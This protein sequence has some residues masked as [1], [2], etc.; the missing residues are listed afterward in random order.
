MPLEARG[1]WIKTEAQAAGD[2]VAVGAHRNVLHRSMHIAYAAFQAVGLEDGD[3]S[4]FCS[5]RLHDARGAFRRAERTSINDIK[6]GPPPVGS[7]VDLIGSDFR[8]GIVANR[9]LYGRFRTVRSGRRYRWQGCSGRQGEEAPE[10]TRL[11]DRC[12]R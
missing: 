12:T 11:S 7:V 3:C 1:A 8:R 9:G 5:Q 4:G 2:D 6:P 10:L